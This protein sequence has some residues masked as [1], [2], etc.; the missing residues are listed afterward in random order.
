MKKVQ[1]KYNAK[2]GVKTCKIHAE[3][4]LLIHHWKPR[5]HNL[6]TEMLRL[7]RI[8]GAKAKLI[9]VVEDSHHKQLEAIRAQGME[10]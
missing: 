9:L 10:K 5:G 1:K 6:S 8:L 3:K 4:H 7:W 2:T